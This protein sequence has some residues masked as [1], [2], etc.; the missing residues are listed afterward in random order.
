MQSREEMKSAPPLSSYTALREGEQSLIPLEQEGIYASAD[1]CAHCLT[2]N[3]PLASGQGISTQTSSK[4]SDRS[5]L[6]VP[7]SNAPSQQDNDILYHYLAE[8]EHVE[9]ILGQ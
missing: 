3:L 1:P 4:Q 7:R 9:E 6:F 5:R 2:R 8:K